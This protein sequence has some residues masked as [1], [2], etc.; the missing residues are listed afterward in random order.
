[1]R[2]AHVVGHSFGGAVALQLALDAP[3][4]V[5]SLALL[6]PALFV[7]ASA[8]EDVPHRV[9]SL[10]TGVLENLCL[11]AVALQRDTNR[12]R[13][14][15]RGRVVNGDRVVDRV[16]ANPR[17]AFDQPQ[18]LARSPEVGLVREVR[19][20]DNQRVAFPVTAGVTQILTDTLAD[21]RTSI[22]GN[23]ARLVDHLVRDDDEARAL[24][25]AD[26]VAVAARVDDHVRPATAR[27]DAAIAK[28]AIG[29]G[30]G[31][32][33]PLQRRCLCCRPCLCFRCEWR[34][35]AI[36]RIDDF[37]CACR[38]RVPELV[39]V[40]RPGA[41]FPTDGRRTFDIALRALLEHSGKFLV[42][43]FHFAAKF[44]RPLERRIHIV[45]VRPEPL[46]VRITPRGARR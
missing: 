4:L 11:L 22:H 34:H 31:R 14:R 27:D 16:G 39:P 25:D 10:V 8:A 23:D 36:R 3:D 17:E 42:S 5:H 44:S 13:L 40:S 12:P 45:V 33:A 26:D 37:R 7:G 15:E 21:V 30:V 6:E 19:H 1:M 24:N 2:R 35:A 46:D 32:S 20:L 9:V 29:P 43:E 41:G 18:R 28:A 38:L